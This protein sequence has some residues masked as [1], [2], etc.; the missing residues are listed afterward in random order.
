M[1]DEGTQAGPADG[2]ER[3]VGDRV[4]RH[5]GPSGTW[6]PAVPRPF[7]VVEGTGSARWY[8]EPSEQAW[9]SVETAPTV[10]EPPGFVVRGDWSGG[11]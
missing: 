3:Q 11:G 5:H 2:A 8:W 1:G 10:G 6:R 9:V 7:E 4:F